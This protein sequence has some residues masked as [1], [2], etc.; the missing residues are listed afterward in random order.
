MGNRLGRDQDG[1]QQ[2]VDVALLGERGTDRVELFQ[3]AKQIAGVVHG[4]TELEPHLHA[5]RDNRA[6]RTNQ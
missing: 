2:A 5:P 4:Y 3:A 1:L 6:Q